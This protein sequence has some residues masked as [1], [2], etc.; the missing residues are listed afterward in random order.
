VWPVNSLRPSGS[1]GKF[2]YTRDWL[3]KW[4]IPLLFSGMW[5]LINM[6]VYSVCGSQGGGA[7]DAHDQAVLSFSAVAQPCACGCSV[8]PQ[9]LALALNVL[10]GWPEWTRGMQIALDMHGD[11][12]AITSHPLCLNSKGN[13]NSNVRV[14][15]NNVH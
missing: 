5:R 3:V 11:T 14:T 13:R 10:R 4:R 12:L 1:T 2:V 7:R 9:A 6:G 15:V 8:A